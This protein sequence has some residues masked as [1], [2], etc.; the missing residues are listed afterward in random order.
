MLSSLLTHG[1]DIRTLVPR[2]SV[3]G[4]GVV[5]EA[6]GYEQR[7]NELYSWDGMKRGTEPFLVIQHTL[8]GEGRLDFGGA[9]H[10]LR[11]GQTMLVTM[12]HAHRYW[13]ERGGHW[14]YF[15]FILSGREAL[16]L[17]RD[18]LAVAG[19]VL[20]PAEDTAAQL[21]GSCHA[22]LTRS[23]TPAQA[24][25]LGYQ[26]LALLHDVAFA[27]AR[28]RTALAPELARVLAHVEAH[29]SSDLR[30]DALAQVAGLS[31]AH[32]VRRFAAE[33]G[34]PPSDH[35]FARRMDRVE[36]LL[37]ASEMKIAEIARATGFAD[38]NYLAKAFR[39]H[40]NLSPMEFRARR[41]EAV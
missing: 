5:A 9:R 19:P 33:V 23:L 39:R 20:Q 38:A 37:T 26:A 11:P 10:R 15:W 2:G 18:V 41:D 13:L 3:P 32:F 4:L 1:H 29:L 31:R 14:E 12:P 36:R 7:R 16:R 24:S 17:G 21:A 8:L 25:V 22:L 28:P 27:G 30:V 6:A 40:R 34:L 35:V